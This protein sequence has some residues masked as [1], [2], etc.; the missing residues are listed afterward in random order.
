M[1]T[2]FHSQAVW[3]HI[4]N[5]VEGAGRTYA[6]IAFI[7]K[8]APERLPLGSGDVLLVNAS[9][10]NVASGATNPYALE[11][12]INSGVEVHTSSILHAK[13]ISTDR[14]AVVGSANASASSARAS[15]AVL[16]TTDRETRKE[17][18][19]FVEH[20]IK[21]SGGEI[22]SSKL[23][24]LKKIF[25]AGATLHRITGV[26]TP[27]PQV[28]GFPWELNKIYIVRWIDADLTSDEVVE[29]LQQEKEGSLRQRKTGFRFDLLQIVDKEGAFSRGDIIFFINDTHVFPP[30]RIDSDLIHHEANESRMGQITL[31]KVDTKKE[32][33]LETVGR[34]YEH[35]PEAFDTLLQKIDETPDEFLEISSADC[36]GLIK[37]WYPEF[38]PNSGS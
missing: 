11:R 24:D 1:I 9:D 20:E 17:V 2:R 7:G 27:E 30:V 16:I 21:A 32:L 22:T 38:M 14:H 37:I 26:N 10:Q 28:F 36:E 19:E 15:E 34:R 3:P 4:T 23:S 35:G 6:A 33:R 8:D 25:D 18:R 31:H 5:V 29:L 13:V 12:F